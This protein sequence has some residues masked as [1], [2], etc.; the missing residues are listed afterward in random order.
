M[1]TLT[2]DELDRLVDLMVATD[3]CR[4]EVRPL[5]LHGLP[6]GVAASL[7]L[8]SDDLSQLRA[9][10]QA[11]NARTELVGVVGP[12]LGVWLK[13]AVALARERHLPQASELASL[14]GQVGSV[15]VVHAVSSRRGW[16]APV[17]VAVAAAALAW[18]FWPRIDGPTGGAPVSAPPPS[19][20]AVVEP[21]PG[22]LQPEELA[23]PEPKVVDA[24]SLV[25]P[26]K[27]VPPTPLQ[28][29]PPTSPLSDPHT[30]RIEAGDVRAG[31]ARTVSVG[32]R[33]GGHL[34]VKTGKVKAEG[35]SKI[36]VARTVVSEGRNS[37]DVKVGD[38][39]ADGEGEV[40]IGVVK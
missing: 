1:K 40:N 2:R 30:S 18:I 4:A 3:L 26:A 14:L 11:L 23:L 17:V 39:E 16:I 6:P 31:G 33:P 29:G 7:R 32:E 10:V 9:D 27:G 25:E 20:P 37:Q 36:N 38:I 15:P 8:Q 34:E 5:L 35:K 24:P 19:A 21:Q 13:N 12:P 28:A 22:Q